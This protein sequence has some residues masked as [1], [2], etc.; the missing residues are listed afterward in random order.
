M[1]D[2]DEHVACRPTFS[3][4]AHYSPTPGTPLY[5]RMKEE[6]RLLVDVP[7]EEM[8]AFKQPWFVHPEFTLAEAEKAQEEAYRRDFHQL[9]PSL[10]RYIEAEYEGWQNLKDSLKPHLRAAPRP[11]PARCGNTGAPPRNRDP[12]PSDQGRTRAA[13]LRRLIESDFGKSRPHEVLMARTLHLTGR[14]R[15]VRTKHFGDAI[16]PRTRVVKYNSRW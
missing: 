4:F 14:L 1:E 3:Q 2:V 10:L 9:G 16:Q 8:H 7:Y 6:G 12:R 13:E 11:T 5:E 15:E